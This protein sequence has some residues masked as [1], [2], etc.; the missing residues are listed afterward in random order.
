[1]CD[2]GLVMGAPDYLSLLHWSD[3]SGVLVSDH[4][5]GF[6]TIHSLIHLLP[7]RVI[8]DQAAVEQF[9][10]M[11]IDLKDVANRKS[12][13]VI[14]VVPVQSDNPYQAPMNS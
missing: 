14:Q 13:G 10:D 1:L 7:M 11:A 5:I 2:D 12:A 4:Y 3:V 9:L 6:R 8:G